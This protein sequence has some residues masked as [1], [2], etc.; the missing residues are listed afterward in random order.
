MPFKKFRLKKRSKAN[1]PYSVFNG[2]NQCSLKDNQRCPVQKEPL[3]A[4]INSPYYHG[5]IQPGD[6]RYCHGLCRGLI[7]GQTSVP[8]E[9]GD[10]RHRRCIAA[11]L[12][13]RGVGLSD[14]AV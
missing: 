2:P 14:H 4:L 10:G 13:S 8:T 9:A 12:R 7:D 11:I 5:G 6:Y 1:P 3:D